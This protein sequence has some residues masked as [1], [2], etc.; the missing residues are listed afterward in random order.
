VA[1]VARALCCVSDGGRWH[2]SDIAHGLD[3]KTKFRI[4]VFF[5]DKKVFSVIAKPNRYDALMITKTKPNSKHPF[6]VKKI[7]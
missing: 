2:H 1:S 6:S 7:G 5:G 3:I 4:F